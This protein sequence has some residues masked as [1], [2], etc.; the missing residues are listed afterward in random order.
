M[1]NANQYVVDNS[2]VG[3]YILTKGSNINIRTGAG[4]GYSVSKQLAASGS[5][6]G[7]CSGLVWN[8]ADPKYKWYEIA[9]TPPLTA[10]SYIRTDLATLTGTAPAG[11]STTTTTASKDTDAQAMMNEI[12]KTDTE[13]M[14][15]LNV[16]AA[17]I[18]LL[19][20][21]G[22]NMAAQIAEVAR[23]S[24]SVA[25]RQ[26]DIEKSAKQSMWGK[27]TDKISSATSSAWGSLKKLFGLQ[28]IEGI[29]IVITTTTLVIVAVS[30]VVGAGATALALAK[31]WKDA[32]NIDKKAVEKI[33]K[34][35]EAAG[36][37]PA[38]INKVTDIASKEIVNA[39]V[40][41]GRQAKFG[42]F[43]SN[44]K[45]IAIAGIALLL[46]PKVMNLV[47]ENKTAYRKL[48]N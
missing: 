14:N 25:K 32:S 1:L 8:D 18:V 41:G 12:S 31:P 34:E 20:E 21:K 6:A 37:D 10:K 11:T 42:K 27:V 44:I 39:F 7:R 45:L 9:V 40:D 5:Y 17:L 26:A 36:V 28:G 38:A 15:N 47:S 43:F 24:D 4:T 2:I 23:I 16:C 30:V 33:R 48:R 13:T 46:A 22:K 29:G 35:L 3:M 19:K